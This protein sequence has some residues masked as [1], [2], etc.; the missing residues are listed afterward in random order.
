ML[1]L[2]GSYSFKIARTDD[3]SVDEQKE[4]M[5]TNNSDE[6]QYYEE[7]KLKKIK[8][9]ESLSSLGVSPV[10]LHSIA[11]HQ[12]YPA[13]KQ[14]I[15]KAVVN[16]EKDIADAYGVE[17]FNLLETSTEIPTESVK[18]ISDIDRLTLEIKEKLSISDYKSKIQLL[19]LTPESWSRKYAAEYFNVSEYL[20][21]TARKLKEQNGI[22]SIPSSKKGSTLNYLMTLLCL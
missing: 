11:H 19:T 9:D 18:K 6:D 4:E 2:D 13:A 5:E 20:I 14:K 21:R 8:L 3:D 22:L 7:N 15:L 10:K 1:F 17:S 16:I 12:R